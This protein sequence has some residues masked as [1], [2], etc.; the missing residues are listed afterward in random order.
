MQY[1]HEDSAEWEDLVMI[2]SGTDYTGTMMF[3]S[4]GDFEIR[5]MGRHQGHDH[6]ETLHEVAEHMHV[7]RAHQD[8]GV[9]FQAA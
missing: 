6:M 9:N 1:R 4:S 8:V 2:L 3:T 7:G 5:V